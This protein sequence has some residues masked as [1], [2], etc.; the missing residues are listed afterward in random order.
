[1]KKTWLTVCAAAFSLLAAGAES[2][3]FPQLDAPSDMIIDGYPT[4]AVWQQAYRTGP[5]LALSES[6]NPVTRQTEAYAFCDK[7]ALYLA[8]RCEINDEGV[9]KETNNVFN[10]DEVEFMLDAG[11][12]GKRSQI[13]VTSF[14]K[15]YRVGICGPVQIAV[16]RGAT[17]WTAEFRIPYTSLELAPNKPLEDHW[18]VHLGRGNAPLKEFSAWA[19]FAGTFHEFD[20]HHVVR[21]IPAPLKEIQTDQFN[22]SRKAVELKLPRQLF[23]TQKTLVVELNLNLKRSLKKFRAEAVVYNAKGESIRQQTFRPVFFENKY[24]LDINGLPEGRYNLNVTLLDADGKEVD[25]QTAS[26]WRIPPAKVPENHFTIKD[27]NCYL[28]GEF[29]F[30]IIIWQWTYGIS[31]N[32][33]K[34]AEEI[35]LG[36]D[37]YYE[38]QDVYLKDIKE[39]GF[40][41]L[42][43]DGATYV[44]Q[45]PEALRGNILSWE[46]FT[47]WAAKQMGLTWERNVEHVKKFGLWLIPESPYIHRDINDDRIDLFVK[48]ILKYRDCDAVIA[49]SMAD[50]TDSDV[51]GNL[52]RR[53]LY[54]AIDPY[55]PVW[56][57][58]I[59]A[60][61][62][63]ADAPDILSSDPYPIPH[64]P[65]TIVASKGDRLAAATKGKPG[66]TRW[67]WLQN[68]GDE[69]D[70]T[71]P[72]TPEELQQMTT[73]ALNHGVKGLAYFTYVWPW[74]REL[75]KRQNPAAWEALKTINARTTEL[76]PMYCLGERL[77]VGRQGQLDLA[78]IRYQG[79]LY[80]SA[81]NVTDQPQRGEITL[82]DPVKFLTAAG[83]VLYE[84]R[85]V[86]VKKGVLSEE[87][88]PC[89]VRIYRF[90]LK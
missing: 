57:N 68:F 75:G 71:R 22:R 72:P 23:D 9:D 50:E 14:G 70:W 62:E 82:P 54:H 2:V 61:Q 73:L 11:N 15:T 36:A 76:A 87:F 60:L 69:G 49:W 18:R 85:S 42:Y 20:K 33:K 44:D 41:T 10:C 13:G 21:G 58:V 4:E 64:T 27:Q 47:P 17:H 5:F 59:N 52:H 74:R 89:A 86:N 65:V 16:Q 19:Q 35:P 51:K 12:T 78:I 67:M 55:R 26:F 39:H 45:D 88:A 48:Q 37:W 83:E 46:W 29:F 6:G 63:N 66:Q 77:F 25:Q 90:P 43:C 24:E 84:N 3:T 28:N 79:A 80:V 38:Q 32:A 7:E 31:N 81:V 53:D 56:L 30:P 40:N 8:F 1:M 34:R